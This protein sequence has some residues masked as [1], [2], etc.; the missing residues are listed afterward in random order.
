[1]ILPREDNLILLIKSQRGITLVELM[2]VIVIVGIIASIAYPSYQGHINKTRRT[3]GQAMMLKIMQEQ[4]KYFS[5]ENTY[6]LDLINDLGYIDSGDGSSTESDEG[7]Y[8]ISAGTCTVDG[9]T[10]AIN[11]CVQLTATPTFP[12][13]DASDTLTYNS[14]N[15]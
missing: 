6:T 13:S 12:T 9:N 4:R 7:F 3:D 15:Q 5:N 1:M 2:M 11:R 8:I 10:L 14:R